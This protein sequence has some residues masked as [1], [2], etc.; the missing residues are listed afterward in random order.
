M[1]N[2]LPSRPAFQ[3]MPSIAMVLV[4]M[5]LGV[6]LWLL[7]RSD[8]EEERLTLIKDILW[9]E[10]NIHFHLT[11]D[12]EKLSQLAGDLGRR[13]LSLDLLENSARAL[14][15]NNPEFERLLLRDV[16]G[17]VAVAVP[18]SLGEPSG[19]AAGEAAPWWPAFLLARS[20]GRVAWSPPYIVPGRGAA[21]EAHVPVYQDHAFVGMVVAVVSVDAVLTHHVP[22]W[23]AEKYKIEIVDSGG[24]VLGAKTGVELA[25]PGA[26]HQVRL[27]P[28]GQGL[29]VVA[30]AYAAEGKLVRNVLAA[31]IFIL[32]L[33]ALSSLALARRH[34]RRRLAAEKALG[35]EH[36][37]R[38]AMED[39]LT[40][41][42]RARDLDGRV[43]Y[44]NPAFCRMV[45]WQPEELV[46]IV[47]PMPYWVPELLDETMR[48]HHKVLAGN[49]PRD[50][51]EI[52]FRRRSG[53]VFWA[54]IYEAPLI[55]ADGQH[56]GWMASVVDIT[57]RKAAEE[58]AH[59]QQEKLQRT[60][61]L[62]T[63]GEMASTLAHE[64]N[65]PLSA[66]ASYA[67]GCLNR[68]G[69]AGFSA[70]ELRAPLSK[71][72]AQ[73]LRAGQIIR[74]VH[75]FVRK[76]EPQL[77]RCSLQE[78]LT[79]SV[80]FIELDAKKNGVGIAL[81]LPVGE[82][83]VD[84]DKVLLEQVVM[85]LAR[86]GIEAMNQMKGGKRRLDVT[87]QEEDGQAMVRIRDFGTG[88]ADEVEASLFQPFFTTKEE[89]MGMGLNICRSIIEFHRGRLWFEPHPQG[90]SIFVFSLPLRN[91]S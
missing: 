15:A 75:D 3:A 44:V 24:A 20:T 37:F 55:D 51:F 68:L 5:L 38:K 13:S 67:T 45:G 11:S 2:G 35:E 34:V 23:V 54:L 12:E 39:S 81:D 91:Q 78:L 79:E 65:Q 63:M 41:G 31:S 4:V 82:L 88:I 22:W 46:G 87:L 21:F 52:Q 16:G 36:A 14:I 62:I 40:V 70:E 29:A 8:Q 30:T 80:A 7:H 66:I 1:P 9:V 17:Q 74:R 73:A 49:A 19:V 32:A 76:S 90:G 43:T 64:L 85:N 10:Q 69:A 18:P 72:V 83:E 57:E 27:E 25:E 84:G 6:L 33:L 56:T 42:M 61:R 53:E 77:R 89:G 86:N 60:S 71:L 50:G 26:S 47:P 48:M 28:P 59:Q 58:L